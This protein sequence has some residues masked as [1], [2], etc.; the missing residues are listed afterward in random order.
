MTAKKLIIPLVMA[1]FIVCLIVPLL[2]AAAQ[3]PQD[4]SKQAK[5]E[6]RI[7]IPKEIKAVLEEGLLTKQGRRDIPVSIFYNLFLP[8]RENLHA[9]IFLKIKNSG[10]GFSPVGAAVAPK[11][12]KISGPALQEAVARKR[13]SFRRVLTS[14]WSSTAWRRGSPRVLERP[15][16]PRA[17][18][19][20]AAP[21]IRKKKKPT[22]SVI[23]CRRASTS[24]PW[25]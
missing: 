11:T 22:P 19:S 6:E 7:F 4:K 2:S 10:L 9:I 8:A 12:G 3:R 24:W 1:A 21:L 23:L 18:R 17:L 13:S 25:P 5:S 14:F 16:F 20:R 15:M